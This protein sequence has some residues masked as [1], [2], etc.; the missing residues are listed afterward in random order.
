M[1]K[2]LLGVVIEEMN[3]NSNFKAKIEAALSTKENAIGKKSH[4]K[5]NP[6][7][8][9]PYEQIRQGKDVLSISLNS[10]SVEQLKDVILEHNMDNAKLAM[11]W[12][13][14]ERLIALIIDLAERRTTKGEVFLSRSNIGKS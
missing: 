14:K 2:K 8:I 4:S 6:S 13:N 3:S 7:T 5:R 1:L 11:K 12:K 9:N 10:L